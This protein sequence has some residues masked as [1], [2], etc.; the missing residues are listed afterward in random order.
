MRNKATAFLAVFLCLVMALPSLGFGEESAP[1]KFTLVEESTF[2]LVNGRTYLYEHVKTGALVMFIINDDLNR[3]FQLNFR[4]PAETDMGVSHVF[5]HATL[6]GSEK[7]PSEDLFFNLSYQTYNTYMNASTANYMTFYPVA[8]LSEEQLL[9]YADYYTD[10]CF[11]PLVTE[12]ESMFRQEAWR[13]RMD[14]EDAPLTIEGTV[15]SEMK[16]AYDLDSAAWFNALKTIYPGSTCGN[17]HGGIPEEIINMTWE[18]LKAYHEKY[19]HPS[20]SLTLIY[21]DI[22]DKDAFLDLL[23]GYFSAYERREFD[24]RDSL[25]TPITESVTAEYPFPGDAG[26]DPSK[27]AQTYYAIFCDGATEEDVVTLDLLTTLMSVDSSV[28]MKT[29]REK[30]PAATAG[31]YVDDTTSDVTVI[32]Y[33]DNLD[34]EEAEIFKAAVDE[35]LALLKEQGFDKA[36]VDALMANTLISQSM[37]T[38]SASVG[39]D[40]MDNVAGYWALKGDVHGYEKMLANQYLFDT[41]YEE[42]RYTEAVERLLISPARTA[43]ATTYMVPGLAEENAAKEAERLAAVKAS[44]TEEEIAALIAQAV[45][46]DDGSEE[47]DEVTQALVSQLQAVTLASLPEEARIY[48]VTDEEKDGLRTLWA[49]ANVSGVGTAMGLLDAQGFTAEELLWV[50]LYT[51]LIG[52]LN[53]SAHTR[54]Q[55]ADLEIRYLYNGVIKPSL[56]DAEDGLHPYIR[57]AFTALDDDLDEGYD[58]VYEILFDTDFNDLENLTAEVSGQRAS[59]RTT[60]SGNG[61]SI[62]L[63]RGMALYDDTYAAYS[64]LNFLDYYEFLTALEAQLQED[65]A[66]VVAKLQDVQQRF[67]SR[68]GAISAFAGGEASLPAFEA[69]SAAFFGRLEEKPMEKQ[70]LQFPKAAASEGLIVG[71]NVQYN[72]VFAPWEK[73][74]ADGYIGAMDAVTNLLSDVYLMPVLRDEYGAYG[75]YTQAMDDGLLLYSYRDPNVA[76]TFEVYK[77]LPAVIAALDVD[78]ETLDGYILSAYSAYA[79]SSGELTGAA[80]AILTE[81]DY[82]ESQEDKLEY[83]RSLKGLTV[84]SLHGYADMYEKLMEE[85]YIATAGG[86]AAINENADL[87]AAV[88]DPF[89]AAESKGYT[90]LTD[91]YPYKA[92]VEYL[93]GLGLIAPMSDD[94]FGV[95]ESATWGEYAQALCALMGAPGLGAGDAISILQQYNYIDTSVD[96]AGVAGEPMTRAQACDNIGLLLT[97]EDEDYAAAE[98][99]EYPDKAD[100]PEMTVLLAACELLPVRDGALLADEPITRGELAF[101]FAFLAQ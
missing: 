55:L 41:Y 65:P 22:S 18:D 27:Q 58:L 46:E 69:A 49:Q 100:A 67:C 77:G 84:E 10:S 83:M 33:A 92:E 15:Y 87:Y 4:T 13:Y 79:Q 43:Q 56:L 37:A 8:S 29:I 32:F 64:Y 70:V 98:A 31:C 36:S 99:A 54:A 95:D 35:G 72:V 73:L 45:P 9:R 2:D 40:I 90:D 94:Y 50:K 3:V 38:E 17:V 6:G 16:G 26:A 14:T 7:Y 42:G 91:D 85:G 24:I 47:A 76:Q 88:L 66:P 44:L 62:L 97:F 60:I 86:A 28:V 5:E 68:S 101:M 93:A 23:D 25:Y 96:P 30:L 21:G 63:Y 39:I 78:Q 74:G 80:S 20:N 81:L 59:L 1:E 19:Y 52:S 82:G 51:D 75:A 57:F 71:G 12:D 53:T 48:T 89:A 34:R 61:V 11:N